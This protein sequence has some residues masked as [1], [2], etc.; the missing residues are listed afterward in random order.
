MNLQ[1]KTVDLVKAFNKIVGYSI[2]IQKLI[3][4]PYKLNKNNNKCNF[5]RPN[6]KYQIISQKMYKIFK[7]KMIKYYGK[8]I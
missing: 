2:N 8:N 1:K 3:A 7:D 5:T 4:F 6:I